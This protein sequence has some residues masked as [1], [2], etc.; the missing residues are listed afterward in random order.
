MAMTRPTRVRVLSVAAGFMRNGSTSLTGELLSRL[1]QKLHRVIRAL[2][3]IVMRRR[4]YE[5][6]EG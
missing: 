4:T 1:E 5:P 2:D 6:G 3:V